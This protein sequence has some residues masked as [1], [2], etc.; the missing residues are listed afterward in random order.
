MPIVASGLAGAALA[1]L[2]E[3]DTTR[4]EAKRAAIVGNEIDRGRRSSVIGR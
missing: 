1:G 2:Y 4:E 3:K